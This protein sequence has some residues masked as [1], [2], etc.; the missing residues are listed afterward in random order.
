[1]TAERFP[2]RFYF[3]DIILKKISTKSDDA[4][5]AEIFNLYRNNRK[6][7]FYWH[8]GLKQLSF[9]NTADMVNRI[10]KCRL[11]CYTICMSGKIIGCIEIT[12]LERDSDNTT[13]RNLSFWV[14]KNNVR[15][16]IMNNCLKALENHFVAQD[17]DALYAEVN[18]EN[19]PSI[20]LLKK[21]GYK[22]RSASFLLSDDGALLC[23]TYSFQKSVNQRNVA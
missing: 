5:I 18:T 11:K 21:L 22:N 6:H 14:D 9:M 7:L 13:Y 4:V 20:N 3:G 16:G 10:K 17:I 2:K 15:K 1:M 8:H 23:N 12:R 19:L